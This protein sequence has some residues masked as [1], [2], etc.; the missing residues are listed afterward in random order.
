MCLLPQFKKSFKHMKLHILYWCN[1]LYIS[2]TSIKL[3]YG[4]KK[5]IEKQLLQVGSAGMR[6]LSCMVRKDCS[7][8]LHGIPVLDG[9]DRTHEVNSIK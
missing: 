9:C 7:A 5:K 3:P 2:H 8:D 1:L 4:K 6:P